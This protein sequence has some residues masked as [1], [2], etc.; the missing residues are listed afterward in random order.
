[1]ASELSPEKKD[2]WLARGAWRRREVEVEVEV[3]AEIRKGFVR[4]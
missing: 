4:R 2:G 1:M 3:E